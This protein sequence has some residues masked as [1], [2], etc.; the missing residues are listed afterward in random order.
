[1]YFGGGLKLNWKKG[2]GGFKNTCIS[3]YK[4][5]IIVSNKLRQLLQQKHN[6][7]DTKMKITITDKELYDIRKLYNINGESAGLHIETNNEMRKKIET[8]ACGVP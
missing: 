4:C 6:N 7:G 2:V 3:L 1:L 8:Y 5:C